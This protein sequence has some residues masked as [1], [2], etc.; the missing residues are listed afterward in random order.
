MVV[1]ELDL[2]INPVVAVRV[3]AIDLPGRGHVE[4]CV[5]HRFGSPSGTAE[6]SPAIHR[7]DNGK[8][9]GPSPGGAKETTRSLNLFFRP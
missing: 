4:A 6:H 7:W 1:L 3:A 8:P 5:M 9:N 2:A